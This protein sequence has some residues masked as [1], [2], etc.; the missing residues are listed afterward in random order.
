MNAETF[1]ERKNLLEEF[2]KQR[3]KFNIYKIDICQGTPNINIY[4]EVNDIFFITHVFF[5]SDKFLIRE[6]YKHLK[7]LY[8]MLIVTQHIKSFSMRIL[9]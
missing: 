8:A 9:I 5:T 3:M 6:F 7:L 1:T 2:Y 4:N